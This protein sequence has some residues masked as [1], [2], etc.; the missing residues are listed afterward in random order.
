MLKEWEKGNFP[1]TLLMGLNY[2]SKYGIESK[3]LDP[4]VKSKLSIFFRPLEKLTKI[5]I[6]QQLKAISL[7]RDFDVIVCK[8]LTSCLIIAL[9]KKFG[10]I[11]KPLV[12]LDFIVSERTPFKRIIGFALSSS[13]KILY[14]A[15]SLKSLLTERFMLPKTTIEYMPWCIDHNFFKPTKVRPDNYI[16][17]AGS[18]DRDYEFLIKASLELGLSFKIL[19][20]LNLNTKNS[21]V[22]LLGPMTARQLRDAYARAMFVIIPLKDVPSASGVTT[23]LES[24]AMGKA[25]IITDSEGTT[26]YVVNN[27]NAL[28]VEPSDFT[29]LK[30][31]IGHLKDNPEE[32]KRIGKNARKTIEENFNTEKRAAQLIKMYLELGTKR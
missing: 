27:E 15:K 22:S 23:L 18:S 7:H 24:M 28:L 16:F 3:F 8:D 17:S 11:R 32:V 19:T 26:D 21:K 12:I 14:S 5:N 29:T 31:A 9:M 30:K 6:L 10:I 4:E 1:D 20:N 13:N 2:L 25:T